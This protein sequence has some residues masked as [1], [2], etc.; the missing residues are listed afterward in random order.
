MDNITVLSFSSRP[1]GNCAKVSQYLKKYHKETNVC[2]FP[3]GT[4][5]P[6]GNCDYECLKPEQKCPMLSADYTQ[7]MDIVCGSDLVYFVVP[8]YCGFPCASFFAFNERSVGYFDRD[9]K[10]LNRYMDVKK[11]FIII[12]NSESIPFKAAMQQ[13]TNEPPDILYL[14]TS[15]YKKQSIAGDLLDSSE[16]QDDL[17]QFLDTF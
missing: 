13:Q 7:L 12:S 14:K 2:L 5:N 3:L 10:L 8:N 4:F 6:C 17:K 15:K 1:T 11:R 9:R 16:A